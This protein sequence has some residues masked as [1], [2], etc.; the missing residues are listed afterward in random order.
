[1]GRQ[2]SCED[3]TRVSGSYLKLKI[4]PCAIV[5][6]CLPW[7]VCHLEQHYPLLSETA[8]RVSENSQGGETLGFETMFAKHFPLSRFDQYLHTT[9]DQLPCK[10][11][12]H[13]THIIFELV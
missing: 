6:G 12:S 7:V 8:H 4:Q 3:K 1:V 5:W 9:H 11:A 13:N 10:D 2:V